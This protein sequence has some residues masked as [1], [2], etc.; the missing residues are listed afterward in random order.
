[1]TA[2]FLSRREKGATMGQ[3]QDCNIEVEQKREVVTL[4]SWTTPVIE[5]IQM[6]ETENGTGIATESFTG[7]S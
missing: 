4:K 1:M 7:N 6:S 5:V 3:N 2:E